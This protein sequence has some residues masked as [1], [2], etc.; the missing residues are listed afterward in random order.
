MTRVILI[1]LISITSLAAQ[2]G[3]LKVGFDIDDT[4]LYVRDAF[5]NRP[6]GLNDRAELY[7]WVNT[8][9]HRY[10]QEITPV[11]E[12]VK[13]FRA[14][15]HEVYFITARNGAKGKALA[16]YLSEVVGF[17]VKVDQNLFFCPK[18]QI[19]DHRYTTK[20]RKM[21]ELEMDLYYGDSD[22]DMM[23][24]LKAD[25]HPV[26]IVRHDMSLETYSTNYFGGLS[27]EAE[28]KHPFS[29]KEITPFYK[30]HVG[31]FGESIYPIEWQGPISK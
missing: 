6:E 24:A 11:V 8:N 21:T 15:G 25:V 23:A 2:P 9:T 3:I 5:D 28:D 14:N 20:H 12:L 4:V 16:R 29:R 19:G 10:A 7:G 30:A 27:T 17:D 18:E 31:I 26:R 22:S 13:Y 1:I